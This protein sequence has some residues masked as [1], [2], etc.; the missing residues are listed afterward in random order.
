MK[1]LIPSLLFSGDKTEIDQRMR[2]VGLLGLFTLYFNIY[3]TLDKKFFKQLWDV[4]KKV[5]S[6]FYTPWKST[7]SRLWKKLEILSISSTFWFYFCP[8]PATIKW[9]YTPCSLTKITMIFFADTSGVNFRKW[10]WKKVKI[11]NFKIFPFTQLN[12][13][14][15]LFLFLS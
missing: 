5:K 4:Y 1:Y 2:Y 6:N 9:E 8:S 15:L 10:K 3:Q 13:L 14:I 12:K 7:H 11:P